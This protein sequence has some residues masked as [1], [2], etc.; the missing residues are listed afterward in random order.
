MAISKPQNLTGTPR[1][2]SLLELTIIVLIL[3][4]MAAA[5]IPAFYST[6]VERLEAASEIQ[7]EAMRYARTEAM[8]RGQPM[9]FRQQN[10]QKRMRVYSLDTSTAPWTVNYDIYHP[11]SKKI[12]DIKLDEHP[13]AAADN[14][15]TNKIFQGTCNTPANIYFD[16]N[17]MAR[18]ADPET[19]PVELYEVTLRLGNE[20]RIVSLDGFSGKVTIQ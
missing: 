5:V 18:C 3:S 17:G 13:F 11:I 14:V 20:T 16:K 6:D 1:G 2:Y 19:V 4:I 9:G 10:A 12:W 15:S 7:A 8:R